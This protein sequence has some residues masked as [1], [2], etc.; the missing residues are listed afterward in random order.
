MPKMVNFGEFLK[1]EAYGQ[2]VLP[3]RSILIRQKFMV[4][5]KKGH[6]EEFPKVLPDR[7]ILKETKIGEECQNRKIGK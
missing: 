1:P 6:F 7:S 2:T 3:H 4:K 5:A